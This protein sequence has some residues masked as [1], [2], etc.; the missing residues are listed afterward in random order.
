M[1]SEQ[2]SVSVRRLGKRFRR[3]GRERD[4]LR[5]LMFSGL[6]R[7]DYFEEFWA[8]RDISFSIR[9]GESFGI[10]GANGSGKSTLL[11]LLCGTSR[12]SEG[13]LEVYGRIVGLLE[14][15][16]G[17]NPELSGRENVYINAAILGLTDRQVEDRMQRIA[18]F[19][20]IGEFFDLPIKLYS[21]GMSLRL[22]FAVAVHVDA[23]ILVIDEALAVGDA[24]FSQKC[25]CHLR[26]FSETGTLILVSHDLPA[27]TSLCRDVLWLERG[28]LRMLGKSKS[29]CEAYLASVYG[30]AE[31]SSLLPPGHHAARDEGPLPD[32]STDTAR[33]HNDIWVI[34]S[35]QCSNAG[36]GAA[37]ISRIDITDTDGQ[38]LRHFAG[39][40]TVR[41]T[42]EALAQADISHGAMSFSVKDRLGQL[43]FA[44]TTFIQ[45]LLKPLHVLR[46]EILVGMFEFVMPRLPRG[47]YSIDAAVCSSDGKKTEILCWARDALALQCDGQ[48]VLAGL[49]GVT[50][51]Q[52]NLERRATRAPETP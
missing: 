21:S 52:V 37:V 1:S 34:S 30:A 16:S 23:D 8:L 50:L 31:G 24:A 35:P 11:Q 40:R 25:M 17:F 41:L 12:P 3:Y 18:A 29:V 19:A 13:E 44:E 33:L 4:R 39:G 7:Q 20:D 45:P 42:I 5:Q 48:G 47:H 28:R 46:G 27:L 51:N 26:E 14:L 10:I 9:K 43:L 38:A 15:G 22:A 32:I 6:T 49:V 36:T 2:L